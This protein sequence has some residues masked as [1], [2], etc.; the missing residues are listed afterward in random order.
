MYELIKLITVDSVVL[1]L[2]AGKS[3]TLR[4]RT[5]YLLQRMNVKNINYIVSGRIESATL[6]SECKS[7]N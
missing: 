4:D 3:S 5:Q 7:V 6:L 1:Y 2:S